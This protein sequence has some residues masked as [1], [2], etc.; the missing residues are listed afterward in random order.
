M[1]SLSRHLE[2]NHSGRPR[3]FTCDEHPRATSSNFV[4]SSPSFN[5]LP[6][7]FACSNYPFSIDNSAVDVDGDSLSYAISPIYLG[8][9]P[10]QPIP[11]PP[12]GPPF[13]QSIGLQG[14]LPRRP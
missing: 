2:F 4:N 14:M 10:M 13:S 11:N 7:A 12:T 8:G 6:Q 5:E 3:L 1:L 9:I